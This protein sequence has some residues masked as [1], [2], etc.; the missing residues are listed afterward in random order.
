MAIMVDGLGMRAGEHWLFRDLTLDLPAGT[1][2]T[3][4]GANGAG[5]STLLHCLYG[6]RQPTDGT[7]TVDGRAPDERDPGF[8]R[9]VSVLLDDSDFF[10]EL[11][12]RQHLQLLL[13]SFRTGDEP[14][15]WLDRAGLGERADVHAYHLSAGQRRRLLLLGAVARPHHVLLL[16]EPER[17]LDTQGKEWLADLVQAECSQGRTVVMATHHPPL[18]DLAD[19]V[20]T[21]G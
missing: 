19:Q 9:N 16:D 8:R 7:V 15:P 12:P 11:S 3:L 13:D 10:A 21:L 6:L 1:C 20:V 2:L 18:V 4:A 17:A 5:K 14:D